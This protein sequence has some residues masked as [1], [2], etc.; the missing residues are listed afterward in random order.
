LDIFS[1]IQAAQNCL[2]T[3]KNDGR[4]IGFVPTM[5]ALHMGHVSLLKKAKKENDLLVASIFVNPLQFNDIKD[6]EKY[7]R[8]LES[9]IEKLKSANC[10]I[11]FAP[12]SEEMYGKDRQL[13][14]KTESNTNQNLENFIDLGHLDKVMEGKYRP[15]HFNGVCIVVK[16]L[17]DI[18]EPN[19]AYFG[20]KDFQQLAIIKYMV[21]SLTISVQIIPCPTLREESG[22]AM[23]SRNT[24]LTSDERK[25]ASHI[26]RILT[27]AKEKRKNTSVANLQKWV[28]ENINEIAF[29]QLDYFEIVNFE[30]LLPVSSWEETKNIRACVAVKVGAVRLIDNI[31]I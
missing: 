14:T 30:T 24:L 6:L 5:G 23:S 2:S 16:K 11:L 25:N 12:S 26:F 28:V 19:K 10:D 22:L 8:N 18:V 31:P 15:G 13:K 17:F 21:K 9:D 1:T 29:F 27:E 3:L 7:P 20:E 4:T